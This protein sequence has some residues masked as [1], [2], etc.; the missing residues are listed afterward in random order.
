M[1]N[2]KILTTKTELKLN[3]SDSGARHTVIAYKMKVKGL[4]M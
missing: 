2:D 4:A 3:F 1:Q